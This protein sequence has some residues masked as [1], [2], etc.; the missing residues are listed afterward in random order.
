[1]PQGRGSFI[2]TFY[3]TLVVSLGTTALSNALECYACSYLD[4]YSDMRCL[5][6][7]SALKPINCTKK[8][9]LTVRQEAI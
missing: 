8:Y 9:C 4:G 3:V 7:A 1:M 2:W 5:N 6:N